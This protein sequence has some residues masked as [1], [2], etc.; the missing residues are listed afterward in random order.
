MADNPIPI[1]RRKRKKPPQP[2]DS[3]RAIEAT[4]FLLEYATDHGNEPLDG[5]AAL[6]LARLLEKITERMR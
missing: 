4:A 2:S 6:G 5:F 1:A 3:E